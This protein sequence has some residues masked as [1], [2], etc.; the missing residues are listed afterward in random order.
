MSPPEQNTEALN[1]VLAK[2]ADTEIH[3]LIHDRTI[4]DQLRVIVTLLGFSNVTMHSL[5]TGYIDAVQQIS[6]VLL[7]HQGLVLVDP[8]LAVRGL[9]GKVKVKKTLLHFYSDLKML[10]S[11]RRETLK[12][13]ARCVAVYADMQMVQKREQI[14][15]AL[16]R[17][18]VFGVFIL[19]PQEPLKGLSPAYHQVRMREQVMERADELREYMAE[20]LPIV[21]GEL[22]ILV[23][24]KE[25]L[26][27]EERK[28]EAERL[29]REAAAAKA[30]K[31]FEKAIEMFKKAIDLMPE[32][33]GAY[34]ESGRV[35]VHVKQY[36]KALVRFN[37]AGE[38]AKSIPGPNK[39]IGEVRI[40]QVKE[41]LKM[42]ESPDSPNI[43]QLLE[44][45]ML[46]F[47][48]ALKKAAKIQ[49]AQVE[50]SD[51]PA[52]V[53]QSVARIASDLVKLNLG[54]VLG[55]EHPMVQDLN[56]MAGDAFEEFAKETV[57]DPPPGQRM[58]LGLQA[59][60]LGDYA[61]AEEHFFRAAEDPEYFPDACD[62]ITLLGILV[63]KSVGAKDAIRLYTKLLEKNPPG[64]ASVNFN[65]AVAY[66]VEGKGL[67]AAGAISCA[68]YVDP[69][70]A[71]NAM[72]YT[73]Y[74][75]ND[76]LYNV[77][78]LFDNIAAREAPISAHEIVVK[79]VQ[80]QEKIEAFIL[81]SDDKKSFMLMK[82]IVEVM[83]EFF[84]REHVLASKVIINYMKGKAKSLMDSKRPPMLKLGAKMDQLIKAGKD[85]KFSKR[86][87]AYTK[88][89]AQALHALNKEDD[90]PKAVSYLARAVSCHPEYINNPEFYANHQ[91]LELTEEI[92][93]S[94]RHVDF[95]KLK[96]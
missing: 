92:N 90:K 31:Q 16:S 36:S 37:Q 65:L 52:D 44:D 71:Q 64:I 67:D 74:Q 21:N 39:E 19:K 85:V 15:R 11:K 42:G 69:S 55:N 1:Q 40:A 28:K 73:N 93:E 12:Y 29:M 53:D 13:M 88:F 43:A 57:E 89:K 27:L 68:L 48:S 41:R 20:Y 10:L 49:R 23:E 94:Q 87:I 91:L 46:N 6:Q 95:E 7:K 76:I 24:K 79:A 35:Y 30:N 78:S 25:E 62:E 54:A 9:D 59:K 75:L 2:Y 5:S 17:F 22:D 50:E 4:R 70:L 14:I 3:L 77:I 60:D 80:L 8:P 58:F 26:E 82:H 84:Q 61:E 38:V 47:K 83:P 33:P 34:M 18:D 96:K 51:D 45:A 56:A 63:R 32:D 66:G 86:L 81:S 72:F